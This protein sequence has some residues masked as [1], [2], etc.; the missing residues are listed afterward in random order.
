[1]APPPLP[2][3]I[4]IIFTSEARP[5]NATVFGLKVFPR[6]DRANPAS[7]CNPATTDGRVIAGIDAAIAKIRERGP[8]GRKAVVLLAL[9]S[10]LNATAGNSSKVNPAYT[11]AFARLRAADVDAI[12]V[13]A[14]G[15]QYGN[16]CDAV[17]GNSPGAINV[18]A[19][20]QDDYRAGF[21]NWGSCVHILAPGQNMRAAAHIDADYVMFYN[22]DVYNKDYFGAVNLVVVHGTSYAAALVAGTAALYRGANPAANASVVETAILQAALPGIDGAGLKGGPNRLL[23]TRALNLPGASN[24]V[25]PPFYKSSLFQGA[26][27]P[28]SI[29]IK[30]LKNLPRDLHRTRYYPR[31]KNQ[32]SGPIVY[33]EVDTAAASNSG[34]FLTRVR[35][36]E[37]RRSLSNIM[38]VYDFADPNMQVIVYIGNPA[39]PSFQNAILEPTE[40]NGPY[41]AGFALDLPFNPSDGKGQAF[42]R[43]GTYYVLVQGSRYASEDLVGNFAFRVFDSSCTSTCSSQAPIATPPPSLSG[44]SS[45]G[46]PTP[47]PSPS[48]SLPAVEL[49]YA[50]RGCFVFDPAAAPPVMQPLAIGAPAP[51][52]GFEFDACAAEAA[53]LR[54]RFFGVSSGSCLVASSTAGSLDAVSR[55][56]PAE[57]WKCSACPP[58]SVRGALCGSPGAVP[59]FDWRVAEAVDAC[60]S[61]NRTASA[62]TTVRMCLKSA[63]VSSFAQL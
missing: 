43:P 8:S 45:S 44:A 20:D 28:C 41:G 1:M 40:Y 62:S 17:P 52:P 5:P 25:G 29:S 38:D 42:V 30:T 26:S 36:E 21:S 12:P 16:A 22:N 10:I 9:S 50:Y 11:D 58:E 27:E 60:G 47:S 4:T 14:A 18:G 57:P 46:P 6:R 19:S 15:N 55:L 13:T 39:L 32:Y 53:R 37:D 63:P 23:N 7:P 3:E 54:H 59:V 34:V 33:I 2:C 24:V 35:F 56:G 48:P 49:P 31:I 61:C 51:A